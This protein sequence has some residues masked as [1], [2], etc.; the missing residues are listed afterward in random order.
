MAALAVRPGAL[1]QSGPVGKSAGFAVVVSV[2]HNDGT[3]VNGLTAGDFDVYVIDAP[4]WINPADMNGFF[5]YPA[6]PGGIYVMGTGAPPHAGGQWGSDNVVVVAHVKSGVDEGRG[7][8]EVD[9]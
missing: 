9:F 4:N 8:F 6:P 5:E 2:S 7:D 1:W 3:P